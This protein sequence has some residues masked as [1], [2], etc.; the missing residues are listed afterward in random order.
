[1]P[2]RRGVSPRA[3]RAGR[4]MQMYACAACHPST[5]PEIHCRVPPNSSPAAAPAQWMPKPI[6]RAL[7]CA[8]V[9]RAGARESQ[10]EGGRRLSWRTV[11]PLEGARRLVAG[12]TGQMELQT[13]G[14]VHGGNVRHRSVGVSRAPVRLSSPAPSPPSRPQA[15]PWRRP[16]CTSAR[17]SHTR[18]R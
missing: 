13:C 16:R 4:H 12:S 2:E 15:I 11:A 1:M 18:Q 8:R 6:G 14:S 5:P 9:G 7:A 10:A 17:S 3:A